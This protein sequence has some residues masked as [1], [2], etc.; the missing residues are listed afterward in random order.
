MYRIEKLISF[1]RVTGAN[2]SYPGAIEKL[3]TVLKAPLSISN[4][5]WFYR[6]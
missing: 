2:I 3:S 6:R 1:M 4:F 5:N